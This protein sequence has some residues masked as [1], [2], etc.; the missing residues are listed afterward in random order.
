MGGIE[1]R[2]G[3]APGA[4]RARRPL[5]VAAVALAALPG[6]RGDAPAP[7]PSDLIPP[8]PS[9]AVMGKPGNHGHQA[10]PP[11]ASPKP[12]P[13]RHSAHDDER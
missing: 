7:S 5:L 3:R 11:P 4:H 8:N 13:N 1:G 10:P 2:R 6:C 9:A 12:K